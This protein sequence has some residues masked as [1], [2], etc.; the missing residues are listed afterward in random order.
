MNKAHRIQ[1]VAMKLVLGA[2]LVLQSSGLC[3]RF[4]RTVVEETYELPSHA[5]YERLVRQRVDN[6]SSRD[7]PWA[8]D[9]ERSLRERGLAV[10][11]SAA[12]GG[13]L[14][15]S[16]KASRPYGHTGVL[17]EV[18][19]ALWVAENTTAARGL[20]S[21]GAL[22]LTPLAAWDEVTTVIRLPEVI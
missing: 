6:R 3:L 12:R 9:A 17:I 4:V 8:R 13:D 22:A 19:G 1:K 15:F 14:V 21:R 10:D 11:L 7:E 2:P 16:Y 20:R 5:L 18:G